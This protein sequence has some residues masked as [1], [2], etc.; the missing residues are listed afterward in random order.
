MPGDHRMMPLTDG[1]AAVILVFLPRVAALTACH[2]GRLLS[3][4][5]SA[6]GSTDAQS[7]GP[8]PPMKPVDGSRPRVLARYT[9]ALDTSAKP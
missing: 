1:A 9:P 7:G 3:A 4:D 8:R 5:M 6:A 2:D